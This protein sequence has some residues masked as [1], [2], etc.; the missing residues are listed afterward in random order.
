MRLLYIYLILTF[1]ILTVPDSL[2]AFECVNARYLFDIK[3][4]AN[5]PSDLAVAPDGDIYIVDGVNNRVIVVES[6]GRW[7]FAFGSEGTGK[8]QFKFPLGID[9]SKSGKVFIADSRNHRIQVFDLK[10]KFL[11]MFS[12]RREPGENPPD[13]VDVAASELND[14]LYVSDNEN[15]RIKVYRQNGVFEF[16]WGNFGEQLAEFRY[17]GILALNRLNEIF[18]VDVL[19]TRV[20]KFD[21]SGKFIAVIG[22]WGVLPGEFFRPKGV[23]I[24]KKNR[25]I[26]SDS[27]MSVLQVFTDLG[28]LI[29]VVCKNGKKM[30]FKSPV[31]IVVDKTGRLL[32]VEMR[33]NKITVLKLPE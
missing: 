1:S 10:G 13:P 22:S 29:G 16:E 2:F 9:I 23:A 15:H 18:V 26:V 11:Y 17:P 21:P 25:V 20:Q 14:Y 3:P 8:G 19:N 7:K 31:G 5:Q 33:A 4:G 32:V 27:Y 12:V 24:D 30:V 6:N 28:Q